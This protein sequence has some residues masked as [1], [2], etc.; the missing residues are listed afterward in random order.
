MEIKSTKY[1]GLVVQD[2]LGWSE[3]IKTL[4]KKL[5]KQIPLYYSLREIIPKTNISML[6]KSL[7][8]SLINYGIEL[9]GRHNNKWLKQLQKAQNRLLKIL[10]KERK[11]TRTNILHKTH[12]ILKIID[13][14]K[15]RLSL[16]NHRVIYS[17]EQLNFA[18]RNLQI[19]YNIHQHNLRNTLNFQINALAYRKN[20]KITEHASIVW[21]N[22]TNEI[23][24]NK[25]RETFKRKYS[26]IL[27]D[28]YL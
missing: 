1:L 28:H 10:Y 25:Y 20:N 21:N 14:A 15:L 18:H 11:R 9:Y 24:N 27:I 16:I 3:H 22:L 6:Y 19:N 8:L 26:S 5:N 7:S 23:K 17:K 2:N 12:N 13:L 4:I